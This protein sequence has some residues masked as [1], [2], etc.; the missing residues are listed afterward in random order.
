MNTFTLPTAA[1]IITGISGYSAAM[2]TEYLPIVFL[3]VGLVAAALGLRWL[4]AKGSGFFGTL[5]KGRGR[6]GRG[7]KIYYTYDK[8]G[9]LSGGY[10]R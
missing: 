2:F 10:R 9:R 1:E 3:V 4:G 6:K 8:S 5:L 7:G